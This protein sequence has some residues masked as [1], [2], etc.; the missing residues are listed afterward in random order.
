MA[1]IKPILEDSA[2]LY[3]CCSAYPVTDA[4]ECRDAE[5]NPTECE[6]EEITEAC[7]TAVE[8]SIEGCEDTLEFD[9]GDV[10]LGSLGRILKLDVTI[11]RVCP[12]KR[13][14]LAVSLVELDDKDNEFPRGLKTLLIP[15][16]DSESCRDVTVRCIKFVLPEELDV[17][18]TT[19]G[20]C[21]KRRFKARFLANYVDSGPLCCTDVT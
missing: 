3:P 19:N 10:F 8:I 11:K 1:I 20:I 5:G 2:P 12:H 6:H 17:S 18:G 4:P 7:P 9:A 16:Q 14:A 15:A 13:V 21:D